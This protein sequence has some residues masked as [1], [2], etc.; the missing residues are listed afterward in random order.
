[1]AAILDSKYRNRT[2]FMPWITIQVM[3]LFKLCDRISPEYSGGA[4]W[5]VSAD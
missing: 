3:L 1:M 5:L 2:G 4:E